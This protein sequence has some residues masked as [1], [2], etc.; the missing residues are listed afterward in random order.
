MKKIICIILSVILVF[1]SFAFSASAAGSG[2]ELKM[3]ITPEKAEYAKDET[4]VFKTEFKNHS[5]NSLENI[6]LWIEYD[7]N[8][9]GLS[10][11]IT[12][13]IY[14]EIGSGEIFTGDFKLSEERF[15]SIS[16]PSVKSLLARAFMFISKTGVELREYFNDFK[17]I[18]AARTSADLGS[19]TVKYDGVDVTCRFYGKY[20]LSYDKTGANAALKSSTDSDYEI[21]ADVTTEKSG[22]SGIIFGSEIKNGAFIGGLFFIDSQRNTAGILVSDGTDYNVIAEKHITVH[23]DKAY[24]MKLSYNNGYLKGWVCYNPLDEDPYPIFDLYEEFS[25]TDAGVFASDESKIKNFAITD[26]KKQEVSGD[27]SNPVSLNS[28]DPYIFYENGIYYLYSTNRSD[29]FDYCTSTDLIHW[30]NSGMCASK[31]DICGEFWFWA[32]E[33]YKYNDRYYMLYSTEEH[34]AIAVADSPG[35]PFKKTGDSFLFEHKGIDGHIMFDDDGK[36]YLYYSYFAPGSSE[37]WICDMDE[38]LN[39][40][41]ETNRIIRSPEGMEGHIN[42]GPFILKHNGYYYLTYSGEDYQSPNYSVYVAVSSSPDGPFEKQSSNPVLT[43][44]D[45]IYGT[46]HHC[47][48]STPEGQLYIAYHSHFSP[49]KIHNR[50]L[51]IDKAKFVPTESGIDELC[52]YGP[53]LTPQNIK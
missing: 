41:P 34:M 17:N 21:S 33:V 6:L 47:F 32:P 9:T 20:I 51:N 13:R 5:L 16:S 23:P 48:I 24:R 42:E 46:G 52:V 35:G 19:A 22:K 7:K 27:Y 26:T 36:I 49:T 37:I 45:Y 18:F 43:H 31:N 12:E 14:D 28:P 11:G 2:S 15:A 53:T 50:K 38:N 3:K 1:S 40:K 10:S 44:T 8:E 4:I 25:R 29:G 39:V 30:K